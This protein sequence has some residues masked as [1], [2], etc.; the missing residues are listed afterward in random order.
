MRWFRFAVLIILVAVVQASLLAD[1][2]IR[3]ELPLILLVFFAIY[4]NPTHAIVTSFAIG[5]TADLIGPVMGPHTISFGVCGTALAYLH[6]VIAVRKMPYQALAI[7][8]A[9]LVCGAL[10]HL[11]SFF[12][13]EP[14]TAQIRYVLLATSIYSAV[15]GPFLFLPAAWWMRIRIDRFSRH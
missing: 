7:F 11:L 10:T 2:N 13:G 9:S 4:C 14:L 15:V 12:Q 5:F 8:V 6:R 3:P 1:L